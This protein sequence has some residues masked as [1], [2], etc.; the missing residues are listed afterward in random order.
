MSPPSLEVSKSKK[1]EKSPSKKKQKKLGTSSLPTISSSNSSEDTEMSEAETKVTPKKKKESPVKEP[2]PK[3]KTP[4][5]K[6]T[7]AK[8]NSEKRKNPDRK[9]RSSAKSSEDTTED[10]QDK[11]IN[12]S[13]LKEIPEAV[14]FDP[15]SLENKPK[16]LVDSLSKYFTPGVKRT[17]R[18]ALNSLIKPQS[19]FE[20][21]PKR[22]KS[23][24][25]R[26]KSHTA[27]SSSE[28]SKA[29]KSHSDSEGTEKPERKRHTSSGQSQVR[30]LYDGL[31]HLYTD[32]DSRLRHIPS[33]NYAEKRR[34]VDETDANQSSEVGANSANGSAGRI[35][36]SPHRMSDSELR[37]VAAAAIAAVDDKRKDEMIGGSAEVSGDED[38]SGSVSGSISGTGKRGRKKRNRKGVERLQIKKDEKSSKF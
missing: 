32:C 30:S 27:Y 18:T 11:K 7:L 19:E 9:A 24:G 29:I 28:E 20:P 14:R 8:I 12:D 26:R 10:E 33:T 5:E 3:E 2:T 16:G 22:R 37:A 36:L 25:E 38:E 31:S 21:K 1:Q 17:S 35:P 34:G 13:K 23:Q 15:N 4:K 6:E